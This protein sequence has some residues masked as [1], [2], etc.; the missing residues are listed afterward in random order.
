MVGSEGPLNGTVGP[1]R[2]FELLEAD[3][4]E[5]WDALTRAKS[6]VPGHVREI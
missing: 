5:R 6:V 2:S 1:R 4:L 3:I